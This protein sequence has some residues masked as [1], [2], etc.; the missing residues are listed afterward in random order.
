MTKTL[1]EYLNSKISNLNLSFIST[2]PNGF[3][4]PK[5]KKPD[6]WTLP[7]IA[8]FRSAYVPFLNCLNETEL[9]KI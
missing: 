2:Y 4:D 9:V 6:D 3:V 5:A 7:G 1:T 8:R